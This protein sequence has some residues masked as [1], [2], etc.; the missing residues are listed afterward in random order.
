[1][2]A[3]KADPNNKKVFLKFETLSDDILYEIEKAFWEIGKLVTKTLSDNILKTKKTGV[4][5]KYKGRNLRASTSGEFPR[6]RSGF[7]R[8][9][10]NFSVLGA[11][12]MEVGLS[13]EY[14]KYLQEGTRYMGRR[15]LLDEVVEATAAE[16]DNILTKRLNTAVQR[17]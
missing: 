17:G 12:K 3:I 14:A 2:I 10:I 8:R 13:A 11:H 7:L 5:Y 9:S 4:L 1:M 6:N 16:Q 15:Q